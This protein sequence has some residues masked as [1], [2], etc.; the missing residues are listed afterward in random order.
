MK[1]LLIVP[2]C[3]LMLA[4]CGQQMSS[5]PQERQQRQERKR[6]VSPI[7]WAGASWHGLKA[8]TSDCGKI[9]PDRDGTLTRTSYTKSGQI[10]LSINVR[11]VSDGATRMFGQADEHA[12]DPLA[13]SDDATYEEGVSAPV[14]QPSGAI[15]TSLG[16]GL[17]AYEAV[18]CRSTSRG[19]RN[20]LDYTET[21]KV[22]VT[23]DKGEHFIAL[24][25]LYATHWADNNS[26]TLLDLARDLTVKEY[27]HVG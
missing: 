11:H 18:D 13:G 22:L 24:A 23:N 16:K 21:L 20:C 7:V 15:D 10:Y 9:C 27:A 6:S 19:R 3:L 17:L 12:D 2:L 26:V 14:P 1:R 5:T 25:R 4:G 8:R